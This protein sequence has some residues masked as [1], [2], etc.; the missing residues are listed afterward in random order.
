MGIVSLPAV[1]CREERG[2]CGAQQ[3]CLQFLLD[4]RSAAFYRF[5]CTTLKVEAPLLGAVEKRVHD[6]HI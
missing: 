6:A 5:R 2:A 1:L 4:S 3:D